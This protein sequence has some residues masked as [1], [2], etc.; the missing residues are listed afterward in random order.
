MYSSRFENCGATSK[1]VADIKFADE[2]LAYSNIAL[3]C[4]TSNNKLSVVV[5]FNGAESNLTSTNALFGNITK[6][7]AMPENET[8]V[9]AIVESA[10]S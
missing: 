7:I 5:G 9:D 10:S 4:P 1:G 3:L 8:F 2:S 6:T